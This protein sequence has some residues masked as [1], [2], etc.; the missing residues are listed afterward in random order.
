VVAAAVAFPA[1]VPLPEGLRDSKSLS[2]GRRAALAGRIRDSA[3]ALALGA[4]STA[5]IDRLNIRIATA[6]AMRRALTR[7]LA[8][9]PLAATRVRVL[10]DGLPVPE[11][12]HPHDA[13]VAGDA[14]C[15][16]IAAASIVA[17]TVRDT[18]MTRL[19]RRY[20]GYGWETN[21]GY[22][23]SEHLQ[24]LR[25]QGPTRHHRRSFGGVG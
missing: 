12:G 9:P 15:P 22:G 24:A 23:T 16:S 1:D 13:L 21:A 20:P 7:L 19:A 14:H 17:K 11:L 10:V 6:L 3:L 8:R 2:A 5:E 18:L 25:R 4:A